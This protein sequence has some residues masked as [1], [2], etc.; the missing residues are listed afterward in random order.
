MS[1]PCKVCRLPT[2]SIAQLCPQ[3][4]RADPSSQKTC[5][6]TLAPRGVTLATMRDTPIPAAVKHSAYEVRDPPPKAPAFPAPR[7]PM[8]RMKTWQPQP[9]AVSAPRPAAP[10]GFASRPAAP[11][12]AAPRPAAPLGSASRPENVALDSTSL[13]EILTSDAD[14]EPRVVE[15]PDEPVA[16]GEASP[17]PSDHAAPKK[18]QKKPSVVAIDPSFFKPAL[19]LAS[20]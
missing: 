14:L 9:V 16:M 6:A 5:F 17:K 10:L 7:A 8:G 18:S 20:V 4:K 11:R 12:P 2:R 15:L 3:H 19:K 1:H 13:H